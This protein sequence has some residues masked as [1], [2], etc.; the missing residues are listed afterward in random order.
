MVVV[1]VVIGLME[2]KLNEYLKGLLFL[3][4]TEETV[5]VCKLIF[6]AKLDNCLVD[7]LKTSQERR[8]PTYNYINL[9]TLFLSN[10]APEFFDIVLTWKGF[11]DQR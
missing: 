8:K 5:D 7:F 10:C 3:D 11:S 9:K 1:V 2:T 6:S 4:Q